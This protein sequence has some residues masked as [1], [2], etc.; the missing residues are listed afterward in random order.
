MSDV[1]L[2][3]IAALEARV[4]ALESGGS[5]ASG[6]GGGAVATDAELDNEW[7]DPPIKKSPKKWLE[8]G[9]PDYAGSRMSEC[10]SEFLLAVASLNDWM[11]DKDDEAGKT[12]QPMKNGQPN[13]APRPASGFSRKTAKLA[14]GWAKRNEGAVKGPAPY[15]PPQS[16]DEIPF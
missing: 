13:G 14:R 15:S 1:L 12:Y 16:D 2:L 10:P 8:D 3:R 6:G 7:G 11:A 9:N 5:K 4:T